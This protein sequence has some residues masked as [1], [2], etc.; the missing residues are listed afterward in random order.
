MRI[1]PITYPEQH[2][3]Q[4]AATLG[5]GQ[6]SAFLFHVNAFYLP[7]K[8]VVDVLAVVTRV[9]DACKFLLVADS[10]PVREIISEWSDTGCLNVLADTLDVTVLELESAVNLVPTVIP[11]PWGRE[12]W[13]TGMEER[14]QAGV[15]ST[16]RSTPLPWLLA[17][18]PNRYAAGNPQSLVL[19]KVLD[20]L[21]DEVFGDLYFE[22][23]ERKQEVYV[24]THVDRR[25]WPEGVGG[26]KFGFCPK[27]LAQFP[28]EDAFKNAYQ[29]AVSEYELVRREID[30]RLD[31]I[32]SGVGMDVN[33]PVP[34][35]TQVAWLEQ[36]ET[37][38]KEREAHLR[39]KMDDFIHVLPLR[40][41]DVVRVP[42]FT[43]HSLQ[44]G[45][46]TVEFQTPVYERKILAFAQ[47]VLTQEHWDT[48]AAMGSVALMAQLPE[49]DQGEECAP[50]LLSQQVVDFSDFC[51][52]RLRADKHAELS[53]ASLDSY[54][55]VM[56]VSGGVAIAGHFLSAE[57]AVLVPAGAGLDQCLKLEKGAVALIASPKPVNS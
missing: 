11:K 7:A 12:I 57:Q 31:R 15:G 34:P 21:A 35:S 16:D 47:K 48:E 30:A 36:I 17:L 26:I 46:R 22:M 6:L 52:H 54:R 25:A 38:I 49:L 4:L 42:C 1:A 39:K 18:C 20:P 37:P 23:H 10:E 51:V 41:G 28:S 40:V 27:K 56:A 5:A 43:P 53:L 9:D 19:L 45:V 55:L 13:Y 24:V 3:E 14:G 33:D 29:Q 44:H 32:K 50:G 8:P 2:I